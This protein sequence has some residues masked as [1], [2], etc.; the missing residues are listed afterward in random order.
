M[1]GTGGL[2]AA[3]AAS[4]LEAARLPGR[5]SARAQGTDLATGGDTGHV[6]VRERLAGR[7]RAHMGLLQDGGQEHSEQ[8]Q[9]ELQGGGG[10]ECRGNGGLREWAVAGGGG[11]G[12]VHFGV[13]GGAYK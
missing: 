10:R 12:R 7:I 2:A 13:E 6:A 4:G 1:G 8:V 3:T 5:A 9:A 11:R